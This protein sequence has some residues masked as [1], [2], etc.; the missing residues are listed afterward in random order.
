MIQFLTLI[1]QSLSSISTFNY[2]QTISPIS[3]GT[4]LAYVDNSGKFS[5]FNEMA[6]IQR[7]GEPSIVDV[8]SS[9]T[10]T[11]TKRYRLTHKL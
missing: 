5:R 10:N 2:S 4:T 11:I 1:L 7:E 6:N 9:C 3:L 8:A